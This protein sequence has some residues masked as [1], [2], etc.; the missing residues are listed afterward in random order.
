MRDPRAPLPH[1]WQSLLSTG[2]RGPG[3][4]EGRGGPA[5]SALDVGRAAWLACFGLVLYAPTNHFWFAFQERHVTAFK[6]RWYHAPM[7]PS[8]LLALP[9]LLR[10]LV[11]PLALLRPLAPL[12]SLSPTVVLSL[13]L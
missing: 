10:A 5:G 2:D 6:S 13:A 12:C 11:L 4:H 1:T 7:Q 3:P 9:C 8:L